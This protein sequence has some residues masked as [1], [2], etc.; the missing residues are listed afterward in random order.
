MN[1]K[2]TASLLG[3]RREEVVTAISD[4]VETPKKKLRVKL[5]ASKT[6]SDFDIQEEDIDFFLKQFED[7]EPGRNPP[8]KVRRELLVECRYQCT[9]CQSDAPLRF[10]HII[11]WAKLKHHDPK[12]ML[13][14]CGSCHDKIGIGLID[15]KSQ[16]EFKNNLIQ[17]FEKLKKLEESVARTPQQNVNDWPVAAHEYRLR[18]VEFAIIHRPSNEI[19]SDY[20]LSVANGCCIGDDYVLTCSEALELA[21][22]VA[23]Y[24]NGRVVILRGLVW[25]NY[26]AESVDKATGLVLCKITGRDEEHWQRNLKAEKEH[27]LGN[28]MLPLTKETPKWTVSPWVGQEIGFILASDS[29]DN[30]RQIEMTHVEFGSAAISHFKLPKDYGLKVFVTTVFSGRIRQVGSAVF[31]RDA[32]LLGIISGVEKYEYDLGRRAVV[33]TL[34]GFPKFT[35]PKLKQA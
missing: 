10:H 30:M 14:I 25:Y 19:G 17:V 8:V 4:G 13:A 24:K 2:E 28:W 6:D 11:E 15:A 12:H 9:I 16:R 32:T 22:K 27:D 1:L 33:K 20:V 5:Q 3:W 31:A 34:L 7:E 35:K 26:E 21:N 23:H 29:E 18:N